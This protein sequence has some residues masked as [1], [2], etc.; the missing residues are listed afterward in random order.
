MKVGDLVQLSM[1]KTRKGRPYEDTIGVVTEVD[2]PPPRQSRDGRLTLV[3]AI[4]NGMPYT[5]SLSDLE[6]ISESR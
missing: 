2:A 1:R 6:I 4:F 3:T 5:F